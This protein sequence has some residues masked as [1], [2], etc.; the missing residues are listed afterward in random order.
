MHYFFS[1]SMCFYEFFCKEVVLFVD[2]CK[3][4]VIFSPFKVVK[5]I[6]YA[7]GLCDFFWVC[8]LAEVVSCYARGCVASRSI[9]PLAGNRYKVATTHASVHNFAMSDCTA[10]KVPLL[11]H[12]VHYFL[13]RE[14]MTVKVSKVAM[15]SF[16]NSAI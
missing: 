16:S 13:E 15:N 10:P 11:T 2:I 7:Q 12:S 14:R 8:R 6:A 3:K 5:K 4:M 9:A 1:N